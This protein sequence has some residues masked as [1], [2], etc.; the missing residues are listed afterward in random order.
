MSQGSHVSFWTQ[1]WHIHFQNVWS[2]QNTFHTRNNQHIELC[3]ISIWA[4][5]KH[6]S[7]AQLSLYSDLLRA[8]QSRDQIPVGAKFS[9]PI[10]TS[11]G[12]HPD[13]YTMGTQSFP[14]VKWL[15]CGVDHTPHSSA[16]VI[17]SVQLYLYPPPSGPLWPVL[18]QILS[19]THWVI[20]YS[21]PSL[22]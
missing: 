19:L 2:F 5:S 18:G 17:E 21:V 11:P 1:S 16:E 20:K 14:G 22:A 8:G 9:A 7:L 15:G 3:P 6:L 10:Q 4:I 12:A 13:S